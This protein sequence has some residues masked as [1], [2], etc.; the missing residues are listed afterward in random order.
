MQTWCGV[1]CSGSLALGSYRI[2]SGPEVLTV[3]QII[4][5]TVLALAPKHEVAVLVFRVLQHLVLR[6]LL[7]PSGDRF[8]N[9][10]E[11]LKRREVIRLDL[12]KGTKQLACE[13]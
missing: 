6:R 9:L 13:D 8:D 1:S 3:A 4:Q 10:V 7:R 11:Q 2:G 5:L 12:A